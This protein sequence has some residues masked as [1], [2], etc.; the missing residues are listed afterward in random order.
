MKIVML[1]YNREASAI[2]S[3][4]ILG[5]TH[6]QRKPVDN[7]ILVHGYTDRLLWEEAAQL[8]PRQKSEYAIP[9]NWQ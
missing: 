2:I 8:K 3:G 4:N 7:S 9:G 5:K 1:Q 6:N